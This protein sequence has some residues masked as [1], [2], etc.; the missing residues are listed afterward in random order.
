[1]KSKQIHKTAINEIRTIKQNK[2]TKQSITKYLYHYI[3][4]PPPSQIIK[5]KTRT[6][7]TTI[8]TI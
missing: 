3:H 2:I 8:W 7:A 6:A 4:F 1:M 5:W